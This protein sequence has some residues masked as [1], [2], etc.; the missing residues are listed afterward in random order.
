MIIIIVRVRRSEIDCIVR[1]C[2][3]PST[4]CLIRCFV[5][6]EAFNFF[7]TYTH[8]HTHTQ[9]SSSA[10]LF[11]N[12]MTIITMVILT[13]QKPFQHLFHFLKLRLSPEHIGIY[14]FLF[15]Y[16]SLCHILDS[17]SLSFHATLFHG[18]TIFRQSFRVL[19]TRM[20]FKSDTLNWHLKFMRKSSKMP[21]IG[22]NH[23]NR[24][25]YNTRLQSNYSCLVFSL[26]KTTDT[27][28]KKKLLMHSTLDNGQWTIWEQFW[29]QNAICVLKIKNL[30]NKLKVSPFHLNSCHFRLHQ[31]WSHALKLSKENFQCKI[32]WKL[33]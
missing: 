32:R 13:F 7:P 1:S 27:Q 4:W 28:T 9:A 11:A 12:L 25:E 6:F 21:H 30:R 29:S 20:H 17:V 31:K 8:T 15:V 3:T 16:L 23:G 18:I 33:E 2:W 22:R 26:R 5:I 14:C 19:Y 24:F 10:T